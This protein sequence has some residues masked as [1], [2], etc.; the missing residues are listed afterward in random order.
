M[1]RQSFK[2][3]YIMQPTGSITTGVL[4]EALK[5]AL[6][7]T[8]GCDSIPDCTRALISSVATPQRMYS[9]P[10]EIYSWSKSTLNFTASIVT[11]VAPSLERVHSSVGNFF[12]PLTGLVN[13]RMA[14]VNKQISHA[15]VPP[16]APIPSEFALTPPTIP[17][18]AI[19]CAAAG[20][21][22]AWLTNEAI[23]KLSDA[24]SH[25]ILSI[26]SIQKRTTTY[27]FQN[28]GST[29]TATKTKIQ[30]RS[31]LAC[32]G[33]IDLAKGCFWGF[34]AWQTSQG[35][36]E[37]MR[38]ANPMTAMLIA[39]AMP[40]ALVLAPKFF[41]WMNQPSESTQ[42]L[43]FPAKDQEQ[44]KIE[45]YFD[46]ETEEWKRI[47]EKQ[48]PLQVVQ[49]KELNDKKPNEL[50]NLLNEP[51]EENMAAPAA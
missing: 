31:G 40:I 11:R 5:S 34:G 37:A 35:M 19:H 42:S 10:Q 23:S 32:D 49:W 26:S 17:F 30:S 47:I 41:N 8:I 12:S 9:L 38:D 2:K 29:I 20:I 3:A 14:Q 51:L 48:D 43:T 6:T 50:P 16:A 36:I 44:P 27:V 4:K 7:E 39:T 13:Q 18:N 28:P 25:L 21:T 46:D 24:A 15:I 1:M 22:C 33:L 45:M